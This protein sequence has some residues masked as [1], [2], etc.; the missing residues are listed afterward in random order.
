MRCLTQ[1][2]RGSTTT[3]RA[4]DSTTRP[5]RPHI[6]THSPKRLAHP[7]SPMPPLS[8]LTA[9]AT[10][11][12]PL[13]PAALASVPYGLVLVRVRV[14]PLARFSRA[15]PPPS[16][17][18][19]RQV[20]FGFEV[21]R[22]NV[23]VTWLIQAHGVPLFS[24]PPPSQWNASPR[25]DLFFCSFVSSL[26]PHEH[27]THFDACC[28]F[29]VMLCY[30]ALRPFGH[31]SPGAHLVL[32]SA[33]LQPCHLRSPGWL[34]RWLRSHRLR[35]GWYRGPGTAATDHKEPPLITSSLYLF[36]FN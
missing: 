4:S 32:R 21:V 17:L 36:P 20:A 7:R 14:L 31:G 29:D 9:R 25:T 1:P 23:V 35:D 28:V 30:L 2:L 6:H 11:A 18:S 27:N 16:P 33:R 34:L 15:R 10:H 19:G 3:K 5:N 22:A 13:L 12:H 24:C 8:T 26:A